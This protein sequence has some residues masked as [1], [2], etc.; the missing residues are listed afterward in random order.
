MWLRGELLVVGTFEPPR[1][2]CT[3]SCKGGKELK[4]LEYY[5]DDEDN[6]K[7]DSV[8]ENLHIYIT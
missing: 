3:R 1:G 5:E 6:E 7:D 2:A 4:D 8:D